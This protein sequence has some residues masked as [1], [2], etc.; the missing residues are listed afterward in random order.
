MRHPDPPDLLQ[1]I[2][3]RRHPISDRKVLHLNLTMFGAD[4]RAPGKTDRIY[5]KGK[6]V[7]AVCET[8]FL[9]KCSKFN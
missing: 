6:V 9:G 8:R 7:V 1:A 2:V 5:L 4:Q 3:N